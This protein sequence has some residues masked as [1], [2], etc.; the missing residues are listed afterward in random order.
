MNLP[1]W[2]EGH[3][4]TTTNKQIFTTDPAMKTNNTVIPHLTIQPK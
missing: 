2:A 4:Q 3:S 1:I